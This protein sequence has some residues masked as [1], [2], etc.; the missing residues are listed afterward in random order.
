MGLGWLWVATVSDLKEKTD[1]FPL[2]PPCSLSGV[3]DKPLCCYV[4][5]MVEMS[6]QTHSEVPGT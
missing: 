6:Q 1:A 4:L 3:Y 2:S 5:N